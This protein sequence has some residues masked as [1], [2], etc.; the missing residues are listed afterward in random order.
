MDAAARIQR[1]AQPVIDWSGTVREA[2]PSAG[3]IEQIMIKR[4]F[5]YLPDPMGRV[6]EGDWID[7]AGRRVDADQA[8]RTAREAA[9]LIPQNSR[10]VTSASDA[11]SQR[12]AVPRVPQPPSLPTSDRPTVLTDRDVA[13]INAA[14]REVVVANALRFRATTPNELA[15]VVARSL[16]DRAIG[17]RGHRS[18]IYD[19]LRQAAMTAASPDERLHA[20]GLLSVYRMEMEEAKRRSEAQTSAVADRA[21]AHFI[22]D[23]SGQVAWSVFRTEDENDVD[24]F[25]ASDDPDRSGSK[26]PRGMANPNSS[27]A[28]K[29]GYRRHEKQLRPY[30]GQKGPGWRYSEGVKDPK[31]GTYVFPDV[32]TP[33]GRTLEMKPD[34]PT[35]RAAGAKQI[36]RYERATRKR[37]KVFT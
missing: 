36:E 34:T 20:R 11:D 27:E 26:R 8:T 14:L 19:M 30:V 10:N 32:T 4:G 9:R 28:A 23:Q 35:G 13:R 21:L 6:G 1:R 33:R 29:D 18:P 17:A 25:E 5:R 24:V 37:S 12:I 3:D 16:D 22:A 15:K 2:P 7:A 31:T